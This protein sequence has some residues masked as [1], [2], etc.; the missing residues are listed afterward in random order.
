MVL[1]GTAAMA[2]AGAWRVVCGGRERHPVT[3]IA[4]VAV[5]AAPPYRVAKK[6]SATRTRTMIEHQSYI[7]AGARATG[8]W[9]CATER[10]RVRA[11]SILDL[12]DRRVVSGG[13]QHM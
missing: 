8:A 12:V 6:P 13:H 1:A 7:R 3:M 2:T 5:M 11:A 9:C 4:V 10:C